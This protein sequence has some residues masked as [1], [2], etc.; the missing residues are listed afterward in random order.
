MSDPNDKQFRT[1]ASG[2]FQ[3]AMSPALPYLQ[4]RIVYLTIVFFTIVV[5]FFRS[6]MFIY[7]FFLEKVNL[8]FGYAAIGC[9]HTVVMI[10]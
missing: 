6:F 4:G 9:V 2:P 7:I 1:D 3:E 5:F 8:L 10:C